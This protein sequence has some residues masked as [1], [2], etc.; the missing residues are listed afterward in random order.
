MIFISIP[1]PLERGRGQKCLTF[2]LYIQAN[3]FYSYV[4]FKICN[5]IYEFNQYSP[6]FS[7]WAMLAL[8]IIGVIISPSLLF[9]KVIRLE[10]IVTSDEM[11]SL[12]FFA[13]HNMHG[14]F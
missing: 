13:R 8:H 10:K 9:F 1:G 11:H 3:L 2:N 6:N 14:I 12:D 5:I 4:I 7:L